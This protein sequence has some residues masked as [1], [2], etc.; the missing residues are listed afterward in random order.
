L[1]TLSLIWGILAVLGM[2]VGFLPCLGALNWLNIPF[3]IVGFIISAVAFAGAPPNDRNAPV[4]GMVC[5]ALAIFIGIVRLFA[6][7]GVL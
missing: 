4:A 2:A 6:G 7:G 5:C 1:K 3:A